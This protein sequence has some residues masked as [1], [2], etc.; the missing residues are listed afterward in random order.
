MSTPAAPALA[1]NIELANELAFH[2]IIEF[3]A[4]NAPGFASHFCAEADRLI[5]SG[6]M[7]QPAA[8]ALKD[9]SDHVGYCSSTH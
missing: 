3:L 8:E 4:I 9:L 2:L 7:P 5:S 6:E 1:A